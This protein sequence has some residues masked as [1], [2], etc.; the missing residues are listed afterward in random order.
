M[1]T[2]TDQNSS[3]TGSAAAVFGLG[4]ALV[5]ST[6][7]IGA[8]A[9]AVFF[10]GAAGII[11]GFAVAFSTP[12]VTFFFLGLG[13][14]ALG[15]GLVLAAVNYM[16]ATKLLGALRRNLQQRKAGRAGV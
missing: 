6:L 8:V 9:L 7:L 2:R 11:S 14:T 16:V 10:G 5:L 12:L 13:V 15:L 1:S 3:G 4:I